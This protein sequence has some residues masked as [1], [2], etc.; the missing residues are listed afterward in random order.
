MRPRRACAAGGGYGT[1]LH[2]HLPG[3]QLVVIDTPGHRAHLTAPAQTLNEIE[4]FLDIAQL[5]DY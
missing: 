1:Y 5:V 4:D 3:S 2:E